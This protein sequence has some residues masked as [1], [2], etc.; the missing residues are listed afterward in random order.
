MMPRS[1]SGIGRRPGKR[2]E[3]DRRT[4][5]GNPPPAKRTAL[6][7]AADAGGPAGGAGEGTGAATAVETPPPHPGQLSF[8]RQLL[9]VATEEYDAK[10]EEALNQRAAKNSARGTLRSR[11]DS[12]RYHKRLAQQRLKDKH[13]AEDD[14]EALREQVRRLEGEKAAAGGSTCRA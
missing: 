14:A 3:C 2:R 7:S 9:E 1:T 10:C 12:L 8:W 5:G 6:A 11:E 13:T 4:S